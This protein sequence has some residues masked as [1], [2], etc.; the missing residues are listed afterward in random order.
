MAGLAAF[1]G[2]PRADRRLLVVAAV[3]HAIVALAVRVLPFGR[4]RRLLDQLAALGARPR[5]VENVEARIVQAV[6]RVSSLM[7]SENCLVEALV[8]QCLLARHQRET[9]LCIGVARGRPEGRTFDAHAWLEHRGTSVIGA[10]AVVY[11]PLR[12]PSRCASSPSPR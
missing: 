1:L 9:T 6:R 4:V 10:S 3:L 8:A 5:E 7:A 12:P 11:D 2:K